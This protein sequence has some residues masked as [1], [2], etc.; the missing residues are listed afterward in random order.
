M[1]DKG[2]IATPVDLISGPMLELQVMHTELL[3][4][5]LH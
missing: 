5:T 4:H 3:P 1:L 2:D